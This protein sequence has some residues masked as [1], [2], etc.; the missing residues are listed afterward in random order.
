MKAAS[1]RLQGKKL[2]IVKEETIRESAIEKNTGEVRKTGGGGGRGAG[3]VTPR[4]HREPK[5]ATVGV[6]RKYQQR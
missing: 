6:K 4:I 5:R 2:I 3:C 1:L